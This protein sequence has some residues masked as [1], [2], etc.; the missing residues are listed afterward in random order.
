MLFLGRN[1][2]YDSALTI[3]QEEEYLEDLDVDD[4]RRLRRR[5]INYFEIYKKIGSFDHDVNVPKSKQRINSWNQ[6]APKTLFTSKS[7]KKK[8]R[9]PIPIRNDH[10]NYR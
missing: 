7:I 9:K 3:I 4:I 5:D 6:Q 2:D 10:S 1:F 8:T